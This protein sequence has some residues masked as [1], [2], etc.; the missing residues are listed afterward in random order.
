[1]LASGSF[2]TLCGDFITLARGIVFVVMFMVAC[3][4][5]WIAVYV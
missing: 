4:R 2:L 5:F 1:M 3:F